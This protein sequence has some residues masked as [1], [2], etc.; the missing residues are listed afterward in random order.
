[1]SILVKQQSRIN[2]QLGREL[3]AV[4]TILAR[5]ITIFF[6]SPGAI[7]SAFAMPIVM[8]GMLGGSL[9]QNMAGALDYDYNTF[10]MIGM[11][12][13]ML[14]MT[15]T[16]GMTSLV[17]DHVIDFTQ[18]M[19]LSPIS[20]YSIIIG[21]ICGSSF[22]AL[23]GALCT[24]LVGF[25]MD[26]TLSLQQL[27]LV[28][29]ISPLICLAAGAL[30]MIIMGVIKDNRTANIIVMLT[31]MPQMFLSGAI[32]PI[33]NSSGI[34]FYLSR[35]L[36]MTYCLD[37][38]RAVIYAET[39]IYEKVVLFSPLLSLC[40]IMIITIIGLIC[41]TYLFAKSEKNR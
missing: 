35:L 41:G 1:M 15:T 24:L 40:I 3:N 6:K 7:F 28:L 18:E 39:S 26:I 14:F 21:K 36:P 37:L 9:A 2:S 34:L 11:L 12:V 25:S 30:S 19:M 13:N 10:M 27:L 29:A 20:R 32:I 38:L 33:N 22:S 31:T 8:M 17:E 23:I 16:M 5:D 4:I